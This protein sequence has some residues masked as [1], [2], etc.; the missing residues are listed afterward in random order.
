MFADKDGWGFI[1]R[2]ER[3]D[4]AHVGYGDGM[5]SWGWGVECGLI[6]DSVSLSERHFS[7]TNTYIVQTV[8]CA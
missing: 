1:H 2:K 3:E 8:T 5:H 6:C 4:N 7:I